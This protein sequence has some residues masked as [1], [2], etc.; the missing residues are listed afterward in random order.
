MLMYSILV[1]NPYDIL[2]NNVEIINSPENRI[3]K[4][5]K[6]QNTPK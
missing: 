4:N 2:A 5:I 6:E 1:S 3:L